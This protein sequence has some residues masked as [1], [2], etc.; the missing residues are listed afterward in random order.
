M[1]FVNR[2]GSVLKQRLSK[3]INL[4]LSASNSSLYQTIRSMSSK[5]FVGGLSYNTDDMSLKEAFTQH[6]EVVEARV[7]TDRD[8][9][10]SRGFGFVTYTSEEEASRAIQAL[11]GQDLHGRRIRVNY[12]NERPRA[13]RYD[14]GYGGNGGY[15][16]SGGYGS[17]GYGAGG[18]YGTG[19]GR[20]GYGSG[21]YESSDYGSGVGDGNVGNFGA[22]GGNNYSSTAS[23]QGG[24]ANSGYNGNTS[25]YGQGQERLS[26]NQGET[27]AVD[28]DFGKDS[29]DGNY[30]DDNDEPNDYVNSR[31]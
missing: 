7:I 28:E 20:G 22:G 8:S 1:A 3:H 21:N 15:G 30:K 24:Y 14:G 18:G 31:G 12:A 16:G 13:P 19:G 5:L 2:I 17:G 29:L 4:E 10:N 9:G 25:M 26:G 6:G 23:N 11:D 27:D